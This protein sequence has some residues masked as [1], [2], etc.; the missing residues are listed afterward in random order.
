MIISKLVAGF[1]AP[2]KLVSGFPPPALPPSSLG[3]LI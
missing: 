1:P 2:V 3:V